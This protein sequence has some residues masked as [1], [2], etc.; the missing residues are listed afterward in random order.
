MINKGPN[1]PPGFRPP[2][3]PYPALFF[4][5]DRIEKRDEKRERVS[6][7]K[8]I[9]YS[10]PQQTECLVYAVST[11]EPA[12]IW[13]GLDEDERGQSHSGSG[14]KRRVNREIRD[15]LRVRVLGA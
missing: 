3:V 10:C 5:P 11:N 8:A 14:T 13:G 6:A 15:A 2:C 9:C 12:G 4:A 7:A 1:F